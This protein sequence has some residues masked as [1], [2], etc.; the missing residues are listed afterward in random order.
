MLDGSRWSVVGATVAVLGLSAGTFIPLMT[1][2]PT[3]A[4]AAPEQAGNFSDVEGHWAQPFIRDLAN[5]NLIKGYPDGT[6][7]PDQPV[8]RDEFAAILSQ[9]FNHVVEDPISDG[10][11]YKDVPVDHWAKDA[12]EEAHESGFMSGYPGGFFAPDKDISRT[13][14]LVSLAQNLNLEALPV[15]TGAAS[16]TSVGD[17]AANNS[18]A[19]DRSA[20]TQAANTMTPAA[21]NNQAATH[22]AA[23]QPSRA[24]RQ[25]R[26]NAFL[27]PMAMTTLLQPFV[28]PARARN[29]APTAN[30]YS[31][32]QNSPNT[33]ASNSSAGDSTNTTAAATSVQ[34]NAS[35]AQ[36]RNNR[37]EAGTFQSE[38]LPSEVVSNYYADA[39]KIPLYAVD[40]IATATQAG[41]VV[42]YPDRRLLNPDRS[43]TRAEIAALIHQALVHQGRLTPLTDSPAAEYIVDPSRPGQ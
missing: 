3:S 31:Q 10:S 2:Q 23:N 14:A 12:I 39:Q 13:E 38:A 37:A 42:N 32:N 36:A 28:A 34:A 15:A 25:V 33:A 35:D 40:P 6:F 18:T 24:N 7:R 16:T 22:S 17:N 19:A 4:I 1:L 29:A 20:P 30:R 43:A 5:Q 9:T 8:R 41:M 27:M 21:A 26:R 11:V